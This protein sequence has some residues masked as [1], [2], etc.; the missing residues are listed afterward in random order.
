M[1]AAAEVA[2]AA[3][4]GQALVVRKAPEELVSQAHHAKEITA[5]QV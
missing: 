1:A 3:E 5:A 4:L 2:A